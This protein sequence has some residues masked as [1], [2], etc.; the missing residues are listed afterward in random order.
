MDEYSRTSCPSVW[1]IGDVTNR[2]NL[3]PVALMEGMALAK[4]LFGGGEPAK[5]DYWAVPSAVF[6]HPELACVVRAA[7]RARAPFPPPMPLSPRHNHQ[8]PPLH[9]PSTS[10]PKPAPP[11]FTHINQGLTEEQAAVDLRDV[12][13]YTTSFRPMRNT[14]SG[15]P[16]RAFMKLVVDAASGRVVGA[17]MVGD[18]AAEILQARAAAGGRPVEAGCD[19]G[20]RRCACTHAALAAAL[21]PRLSAASH[22]HPKHSQAPSS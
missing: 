11:L 16:L 18:H 15:S 10:L 13:I 8:N 2:I 17:H 9:T 6:S 20:A 14:V 3:T 21:A 7:A 4:T 19:G 5:P 22:T 12:D 1:A